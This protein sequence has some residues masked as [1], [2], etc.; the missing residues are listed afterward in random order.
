MSALTFSSC[1]NFSKIITSSAKPKNTN[2]KNQIQ[3]DK[4]IFAESITPSPYFDG[5]EL[6][7]GYECL[8]SDNEK[9]LYNGIV[10]NVDNFTD[11]SEDEDGYYTITTFTLDDCYLEQKQI[12]KVFFAVDEDHPEF[13]WLA[14]P[15]VYSISSGNFSLT[16]KSVMTENEF[17]ICRGQLNGVISAVLGGLKKDMSELEREIYIHD[18]IVKNCIYTENADGDLNRYTMYGCLVEQSAVCEGYTNAFQFLLSRCGIVS[19]KICG[20]VETSDNV[21]HVWSAVMLGGDYYYTDLTWDDAEDI[22]MYNYLNITQEQLIR[23]HSIAPLFDDYAASDAFDVS[24]MMSCNLFIP[25]CTAVKY[26]Y[27]RYFGAHFDGGND[28]ALAKKLAKAAKKGDEYFYIFVEEDADFSACYERLFSDYSFEFS[29]I[30]EKANDELGYYALENSVSI[31][32]KDW[33]RLFALE[34]HYY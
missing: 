8:E 1:A 28:S 19:S 4:D 34:L 22:S 29:D 20:S 13:F 10:E 18:Y 31:V 15:Y 3:I 25:E 12:A 5:A 30:I 14:N 11:G 33:L 7:A 9:R 23:S 26:N 2:Y 32:K 24:D 17:E 6:S 21:D 16:L 27:Y